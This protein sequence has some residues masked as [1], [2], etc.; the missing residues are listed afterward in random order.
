MQIEF[1]LPMIPPTC[2]HQEKR[3]TRIKGRMIFY[4]PPEVKDARVKTA[5]F[6][7]CVTFVRPPCN[8]KRKGVV[9]SWTYS[10]DYKVV[11]SNP[12]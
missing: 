7:V 3:V 9:P 10:I 5:T 6:F 1:F 12:G 11:L 8:Q 4:D 2:T